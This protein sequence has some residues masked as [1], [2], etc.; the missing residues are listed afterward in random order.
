MTP[1]NPAPVTD[2]GL[3]ETCA[4]GSLKR[5]CRV[6][7][8]EAD[9]A[10]RDQRIAD[11]LA[12]MNVA[13][14]Q[15]DKANERIAALEGLLRECWSFLDTVDWDDNTADEAYNLKETIDAALAEPKEGA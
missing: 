12:L 2:Y 9:L 6:C 4:H 11:A 13:L 14:D 5:Q 3:G 1:P 15:R 7:E 10:E 8:L